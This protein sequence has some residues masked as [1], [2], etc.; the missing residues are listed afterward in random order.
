ML[1][2]LQ[3]DRY[4]K[5]ILYIVERLR[6]DLSREDGLLQGNSE[7]HPALSPALS[8]TITCTTPDYSIVHEGPLQPHPLNKVMSGVAVRGLLGRVC[9]GLGSNEQF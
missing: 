9:N 1:S 2:A 4:C 3:S 6:P 5:E 7:T 8:P